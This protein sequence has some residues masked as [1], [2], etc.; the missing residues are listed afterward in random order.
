M[1]LR[2]ERLYYKEEYTIGKLYINDEYYCDT[3]EDK[4]RE[5]NNDMS[6]ADILNI[7]VYGRTAIPK[8]TYKVTITYSPKF[9]T[10]LPLINDVIGYSGIRIHQGNTHNNTSGCILVGENKIKGQLI[11]SKNTLSKLLSILSNA[12]DDITIDII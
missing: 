5:L 12:N 6:L 2:L 9:K 10:N 7:K 4:D 3:L 8:G 1:K 11:N